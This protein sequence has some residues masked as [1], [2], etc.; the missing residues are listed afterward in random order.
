MGRYF[1]LCISLFFS[2][3]SHCMDKKSKTSFNKLFI[4]VACSVREWD[5]QTTRYLAREEKTFIFTAMTVGSLCNFWANRRYDC[6]AKDLS[7]FID[8]SHSSKK[9]DKMN[10][11]DT[12]LFLPPD[13]LFEDLKDHLKKNVLVIQINRPTI[14]EELSDSTNNTPQDDDFI[15]FN[16]GSKSIARRWFK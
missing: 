4:E 14:V 16:D 10:T 15:V 13:S 6:D 11:N 3:I 8:Y 9:A 7:L 2:C 12:L 5:Q 1:L